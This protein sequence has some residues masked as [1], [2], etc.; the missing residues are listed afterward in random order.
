MS[1]GLTVRELLKDTYYRIS[2]ECSSQRIVLPKRTLV[3]IAD[4]SDWHRTR[5]GYM[6]YESADLFQLGGKTWAIA[7]GE[8]CG[9]YP[10][11]RY[12]SDIIALEITTG[13][14]I[15][16]QIQEGL[17]EKIQK[18][19]YFKNSLIFSGYD[20][21]LGISQN[22]RFGMIMLELL[23]PKIK[24]FIAQKADYDTSVISAST[25]QYPVKKPMLYKPECVNF[26]SEAIETV[27]KEI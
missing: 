10:A 6:G 8:K 7:R 18:S 11:E 27:L 17:V 9:G 24:K 20:G 22:G 16:K 4:D 14:K 3:E 19:S 21:A 13:G 2:K 1:K 26:L 15:S 23:K 12:D 5:T 25:L